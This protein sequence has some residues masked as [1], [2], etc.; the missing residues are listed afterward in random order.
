MSR[1]L[2]VGSLTIVA[3][4]LSVAALRAAEAPDWLLAAART[5]LPPY[6]AKVPAVVLVDHGRIVVDEDGRRTESLNQAIKILSREGRLHAVARAVYATDSGKVHELKAWIVRASGDV[7]RFG[8]DE[9]VDRALVDND[10]YNEA[11]LRLINA[12]EDVLPGD[13]F[14]F[15]SVVES[16]PLFSQAFWSFQADLPVR[17]SRCEVVLPPGW[18]AKGTLFNRP[19][20]A[21]VVVGSTYAWE[22]RDLPYV[23]DEPASPSWA[24]VT[25]W[26]GL[27]LTAPPG[28]KGARPSF[29]S[30]QEVSRWASALHDPRAQTDPSLVARARDLTQGLT[31]ELDRIRAIGRFVQRMPYISI[32]IGM[33]RFQPHAATEILAK[34]YGDCKDKATLTRALLGAVGITA[35]PLVVRSDDRAFVKPEW[36]SPAQFNHVIVAVKTA[37]AQGQPAAIKHPVLGDLLLFD[38]T[39]EYTVLGDLPQGEQGGPALLAAG[40][41]G[42]LITVPSIP[43]EGNRLIRETRATLSVTGALSGRVIEQ[44]FGQAAAHERWLWKSRSQNDYVISIERWLARGISGVK[45]TRVEAVDDEKGG[46]RLDV[47]FTTE[48]YGQMMQGRLMIF[49]PTLV[50]RR[51]ALFL[52]EPERKLPIVLDAG[53]YEEN[54]HIALPPGFAVDELPTPVKLATAFGSYDLLVEAQGAEVVLKRRFTTQ[55]VTLPIEQYASVRAFY[56]KIMAGEQAPVVLA[57]R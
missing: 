37:A 32:Q 15:E 22:L 47:E 48:S 3:T 20:L 41:A 5:E 46:F 13:V 18:T 23:K 26:L 38:P 12:S 36:P 34:S 30:W 1:R 56:E 35:Y 55:A 21:P 25:P 10:V 27:D 19:P 52:T 6:D 49:K 39:A 9:V 44:S 17:S 33:G 50:G 2:R 8:G 16:E 53:A 57:T 28:A 45:A 24:S 29:R 51:Q 40:D 11:R 7:K 43:S 42:G 54:A 31:D 14:G 4:L